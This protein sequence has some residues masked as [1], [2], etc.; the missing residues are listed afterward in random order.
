MIEED[1][2]WK[3]IHWIPDVSKVSCI[4]KSLSEYKAFVSKLEAVGRR[5]NKNYLLTLRSR[6][7]NL[8]Q[9]I[10]SAYFECE[11][12]ENKSSLIGS[13]WITVISSIVHDL[14]VSKKT[15]ICKIEIAEKMMPLST[16]LEDVAI[17]CKTICSAF[18]IHQRFNEEVVEYCVVIKSEDKTYSYVNKDIRSIYFNIISEH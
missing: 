14:I 18:E 9:D 3:L 12:S 6:Y 1:M 10:P 11:Y 7:I 13:K 2:L 15:L 8:I 4:A 16:T 5:S 17:L